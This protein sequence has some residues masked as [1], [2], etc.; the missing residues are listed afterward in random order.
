MELVARS[1]A[2][3]EFSLT[4]N[5]VLGAVPSYEAHPMRQFI[6]AGIPVTLN[7]DLPAHVC[8]TIGRE[9]AVAASLGFS[10]SE[11]LGFTRNAVGASFAP[12]E[13]RAILMYQLDQ[14]E[15][16]V[17]VGPARR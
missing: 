8:T 5:V 9:Y 11:L 14:W 3:V 6:E 12:P 4:C 16:N 17:S 10:L 15:A 1:G 2:A 7:T 13:R